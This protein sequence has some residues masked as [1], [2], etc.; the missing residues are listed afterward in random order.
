MISIQ[1]AAD[2]STNG[3]AVEESNVEILPVESTASA[4]PTDATT[5]LPIPKK[6]DQATNTEYT[7]G[8]LLLFLN[9]LLNIIYF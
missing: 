7:V 8:N 1:A 6:V 3:E 2:S 5:F 4:L 9:H